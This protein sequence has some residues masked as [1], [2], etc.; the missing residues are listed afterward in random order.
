MFCFDLIGIIITIIF[1]KP[2]DYKSITRW[3]TII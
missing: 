2:K 3:K 1:F